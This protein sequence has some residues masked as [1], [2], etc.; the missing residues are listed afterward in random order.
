MVAMY[1]F[2]DG[3]A[4][5]AT[6]LIK[7]L[8]VGMEIGFSLMYAKIGETKKNVLPTFH[9]LTSPSLYRERREKPGP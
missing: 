4:T 9:Y 3:T 1:V 5:V 7:K 2:L 6:C 8:F